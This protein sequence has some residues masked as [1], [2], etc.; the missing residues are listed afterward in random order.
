VTAS[1]PCLDCGA[2]CF[3]TL[4][5]YARV[6][7]SDHTRLAERAEALTVFVGN[8]CYMRLVDGH[9]AALFIDVAS[10]RFV[11]SVYETRPTVCR[12]LER[13]SPACEAEI[14]EKSERPSAHLHVLGQRDERRIGVRK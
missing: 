1:P 13:N 14:H 7:G 6:S 2:C 11:C 5:T 8:R 4:E 9:C 10:R 3:S 12:E